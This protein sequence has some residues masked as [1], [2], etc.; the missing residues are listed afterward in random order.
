MR[1]V[2]HPCLVASLCALT[3]LGGCGDDRRAPPAR[4]AKA[5]QTAAALPDDNGPPGWLDQLA[6][7]SD[8]RDWPGYGR[9]WGEQHYS[10]LD[11]IS[12]D[13]VDRLGLVWSYDLPV[14]NSMTQ[15]IEVAGTLY[16]VTGYSI[17][18]ALDA[19]TGGELWSFDPR[20]T[21]AAGDK[22]RAGWGS[23]GLAY[24]NGRIYIGTQDGRL[25]AIDAK[26]GRPVWSRTT[27]DRND[28]RFIESAPRAIDGMILIG[29]SI[30]DV[31]KARGLVTAY[32]ARTGD[33]LWRFHTVPG[34]PSVGAENAAMQQAAPTWSGDWL[35][36]GGGGAVSNAIAYDP[37]TG[38]VFIGTGP[39][40][41]W[42]HAI[43]SGGEGDNL[44]TSSIIALDARTG[45][46]KWHYQ[47]VPAGT[48]GYGATADIELADLV[49]GGKPRK[50]LLTAA[51]DGFLYAI[52]RTDGKLLS[53]R[54]FARPGWAKRIDRKTG[55]PVEADN[56]RYGDAPTTLTPSPLGAHGWLPMATSPE[57][58]LVFIPVTRL[59][60]TFD[61]AGMSAANWQPNGG[62]ALDHG[63]RITF[64]RRPNTKTA[65]AL[66]AWDPVAGREVWQVATP[67]PAAGG[68]MATGGGLVFQGRIDGLFA[69]YRTRTGKLLWRFD[70]GAPVIAPPISYSVD[71][72]QY[73]TVITGF[74]GPKAMLGVAFRPYPVDYRGQARRVLTFALGGKA[75]LPASPPWNPKPLADPN[76]QRDPELAAQGQALYAQRCATCH[77]IEAIAAGAAP[78]LR[79]SSSITSY[80]MFDSILRDGMLDANG[81][82]RFGE[83]STSDRQAI[84]QYLRARAADLREGR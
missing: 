81:M 30:G 58:N 70:A 18:H 78:D 24:W 36:Y 46:Y 60:A 71:G 29:A 47:L 37:E 10:P 12:S 34:D 17:V 27:L 63:V 6:D 7:G 69:A 68:V 64:H 75:A 62:F 3:L 55:R 53:A 49:I 59:A 84:R 61:A 2:T 15:P 77:G 72:R 82:P 43:R 11:Q 39:G 35:Q 48:W 8:G 14:G 22:L 66:I 23:R 80:E 32:D 50:V 4:Q 41:P 38:T 42:N 56:A 21:Q 54:P 28:M 9:T 67:S 52:D 83:F 65:S 20:A 73:I 31:G 1:S 57:A 79:R 76:F 5:S 26:S 16:F 74:T 45:A 44:Y 13:T 51:A 25:I 33:Q 19:R 40:V